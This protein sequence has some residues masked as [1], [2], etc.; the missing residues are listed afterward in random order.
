[1]NGEAN[2][3]SQCST[4]GE[5][6]KQISYPDYM[7]TPTIEEIGGKIHLILNETLGRKLLLSEYKTLIELIATQIKQAK[8][9]ERELMVKEIEKQN[10]FFAEELGDFPVIYKDE[11]LESIKR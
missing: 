5:E 10:V 6:Y 9:E 1:M 2:I 11:L 3:C 4:T 7:T 8:K